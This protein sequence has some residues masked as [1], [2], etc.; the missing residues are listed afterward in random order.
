[1][2]LLP[3]G[4]KVLRTSEMMVLCWSDID[5]RKGTVKIRRAWVMGKMKAPKTESGVR[6]VQLL[7][8]AI[9]ALKAQRAHTATAGEFV[10]HDPRTNARRGGVRS[11]HPRRRMAA[12][13]A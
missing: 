8:P 10:F 6:E 9:N 1:M 5:W 13:A 4:A 7:Q 12:R 3:S 2:S 11:E